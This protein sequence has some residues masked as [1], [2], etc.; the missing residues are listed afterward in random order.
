MLNIYDGFLKIVNPKLYNSPYKINKEVRRVLSNFK[1]RSRLV[2]NS[3]LMFLKIKEIDEEVRKKNPAIAA[4]YDSSTNTIYIDDYKEKE[5]TL[6]HELFHV[7]SENGIELED[8]VQNLNEGITQYLHLK[9]KNITNSE[10]SG[11]QL[12]LFV[13]EFLIYIYGEKILEYYFEGNGKKF[14]QQFKKYN[15]IVRNINYTLNEIDKRSL[16][17]DYRTQYLLASELFGEVV[18]S[19]ELDKF[20]LDF[21]TK[22]KIKKFFYDN[23][24]NILVEF[25][26]YKK[27]NKIDIHKYN[28]SGINKEY[29]Q[30]WE[31]EYKIEVNKMF[32]SI[33]SQLLEMA[34]SKGINKS[35]IKQF[36]LISFSNKDERTRK[37]YGDL[38]NN[39]L[40]LLGEFNHSR[41][42]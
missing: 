40:D 30:K 20:G 29:Y 39:K 36:I 11:Y 19:S 42:R 9:S 32:D 17:E 25:R 16:V 27:E 12:E 35:D 4:F 8:Q 41:G 31:V 15:N 6:N 7:A 2:F 5:E 23:Y 22:E 28:Y 18:P 1:F 14:Y 3:N 10:F 13:I 26:K 34:Y 33:L 38:I 37:I 21:S 24:D